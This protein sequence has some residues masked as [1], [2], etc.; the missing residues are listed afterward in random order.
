MMVPRGTRNLPK[1][2]PISRLFIVAV[3][4]AGTRQ[5]FTIMERGGYEHAHRSAQ[6]DNN[7]RAAVI[8][9]IADEHRLGQSERFS[10]ERFRIVLFVQPT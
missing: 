10:R 6:H 1:T 4:T 2:P 9:V 3:C 7:M 8:H 5:Q